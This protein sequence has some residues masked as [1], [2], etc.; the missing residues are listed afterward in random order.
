[1]NALEYSA[2]G[3]RSPVAKV[4]VSGKYR[5][6]VDTAGIRLCVQMRVIFD[7]IRTPPLYRLGELGG[8]RPS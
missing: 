8:T 2:L 5:L 6:S 4:E 1:M 7:F 3:A